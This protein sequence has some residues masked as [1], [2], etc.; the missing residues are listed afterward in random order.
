MKVIGIDDQNRVKLSRKALLAPR[1]GGDD[2]GNGGGGQREPAM[3]GDDRGG[4]G[5]DRGGRDRGPRRDRD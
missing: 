1:E 4:R 2:N 3:R 5:G